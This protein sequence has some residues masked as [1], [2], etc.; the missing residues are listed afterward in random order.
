M[1]IVVESS[2]DLNEK[3]QGWRH[4][5]LR[6]E[7]KSRIESLLGQ[8]LS[9]VLENSA[10]PVLSLSPDDTELEAF[11]RIQTLR[12][13]QPSEELESWI[14]RTMYE[15]AFG[16][17]YWPTLGG[18]ISH[19]HRDSMICTYGSMRWNATPAS[20]EKF[21]PEVID[22]LYKKTW[23]EFLSFV[24]EQRDL[25]ELKD[26]TLVK[27]VMTIGGFGVS[28]SIAWSGGFSSESV[29]SKRLYTRALILR[30]NRDLQDGWTYL[31]LYHLYERELQE[32]CRD[33]RLLG[34][35]DITEET[36][37]LDALIRVWGELGKRDGV[38]LTD[39]GTYRMQDEPEFAE[40][41]RKL[42]ITRT[43]PDFAVFFSFPTA[44]S[45]IAAKM[46]EDNT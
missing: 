37:R 46:L 27:L 42:F 34:E 41:L 19:H 25:S 11:S 12:E 1:H 40:G 3:I 36:T 35:F 21:F 20:L 43:S 5:L 17:A 8:E 4:P 10:L 7:V 29:A 26:E 6:D 9:I 45:A 33:R 16:L 30:R 39:R 31:R 15:E 13:R 18:I 32:P 38:V 28:R 22:D 23:I 44:Y 14:L 24:Q 2:Q